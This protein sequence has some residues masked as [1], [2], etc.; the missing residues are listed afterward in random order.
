MRNSVKMISGRG[1]VFVYNSNRK[2]EFIEK[3]AEIRKLENVENMCLWAFK[4]TEAYEN[5]YKKDVSE[6]S[7]EEIMEM[8]K[9]ITM[10]LAGM[11]NLHWIL[12]KYSLWA[13]KDNSKYLLISQTD[14]KQFFV[15]GKK[16]IIP[17]NDIIEFTETLLN[18][19]DKFFIYG[20][21]CGVKGFDY[22]ELNYSTME[23]A[24]ENEKFIWLAEISDSGIVL[25]GRKFFAD[26]KLFEFA[27]KA[28]E[29]EYYI[30][31]TKNGVYK[32]VLLELDSKKIYKLP[33]TPIERKAK[34]ENGKFRMVQRLRSLMNNLGVNDVIQPLDI[35]WS[36]IIYSIQKKAVNNGKILTNIND[37]LDFFKEDGFEDIIE[38]Y[39]IDLNRRNIKGRLS[40]YL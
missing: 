35:Y 10:G 36:G 17:Y 13:C 11:L 6:F 1:G 16:I 15:N 40:R 8:Y 26:E 31:C 39:N 33:Y 21:F 37:Y 25:R 5:E 12:K 18:P 34:V 28:A 14:L 32:K 29:S 20:L 7:R 2:Q 24:N 3:E 30:Q 38:Q 19:V 23:G 9:G 4:R 22:C 27:K